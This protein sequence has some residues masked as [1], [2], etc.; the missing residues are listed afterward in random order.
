MDHFKSYEYV[1][2]HFVRDEY[3]F[4]L[5][6]FRQRLTANTSCNSGTNCT[7]T[8]VK[9]VVTSQIRGDFLFVVFINERKKKMYIPAEFFGILNRIVSDAAAA[10]CCASAVVIIAAMLP[11]VTL[12]F[13]GAAFVA[14]LDVSHARSVH[15]IFC[16][17][18]QNNKC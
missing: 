4:E 11:H 9:Y 5:R 17:H 8:G 10:K 14:R 6:I 13:N 16:I 3:Q 15:Q 1:N 2:E 7:V 12:V 18:S